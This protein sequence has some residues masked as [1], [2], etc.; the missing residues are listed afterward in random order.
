MVLVYSARLHQLII[1]KCDEK[2]TSSD[3]ALT[4]LIHSKTLLQCCWVSPA[5][6]DNIP[7]QQWGYADVNI[8]QLCESNTLKLKEGRAYCTTFVI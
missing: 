3:L 6:M 4:S 5:A 2:K 7:C 1:A 8:S